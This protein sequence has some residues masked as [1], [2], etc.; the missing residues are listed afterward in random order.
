[1]QYMSKACPAGNISLI[2]GPCALEDEGQ[3][4]EMA[5]KISLVKKAVE[6]F[7]I[8]VGYRGGAWKPRTRPEDGNGNGVFEGVGETGLKWLGKIGNMYGMP[9]VTECMSEQDLRHFGR[10]LEPARDFIQIGARNSQNFALLYFIGGTPFNVLLKSPQHGVDVEE[11]AG[12]IMRLKKNGTVAYC[13]RGQKYFMPPDGLEDDYFRRYMEKL[14]SSPDQCRGSRNLNNISDIRKLRKDQYLSGKGVLFAY[15]PSHTFGGAD[16]RLRR[17]IG[18]QAVK[19]VMDYGYDMVEVEVN[20][21]SSRARC[22]ANQALLSTTRNVDWSETNAG[23]GP[24]IEPGG[25]SEPSVK[26]FTL[27][28]IAKELVKYRNLKLGLPGEKLETAMWELDSIS[29]DIKPG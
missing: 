20:D 16:D 4:M 26:P 21:R 28:D 12:S 27:V 29:W 7:G 5:C 25:G 11:A 9:I 15:D 3:T 23:Q 18:K 6:P 19:A 13:V 2:A 24:K 1:M 14:F 10:Y 22:D 17:M 8:A